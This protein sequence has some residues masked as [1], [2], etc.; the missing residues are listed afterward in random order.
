MDRSDTMNHE[1]A[2]S[3]FASE[4]YLLDEMTEPER[5]TFEEH[6]FACMAC[7]EDVRAGALM[8]D[9][10]REGLLP[11]RADGNNVHDMAA[12]AAWRRR[13]TEARRWYQSAFIPWA[14]AAS[15]AVIAGYQATVTPGRLA[16]QPVAL[17][18]VTLRPAS[19][20]QEPKVTTSPAATVVT[21]AVDLSSSVAGPSLGYAIRTA[22]GAAVASGS[23]PAP[24][25]G[26]PLLLLVPS[27]EIALPGRYILVVGDTEYPF[28]VVAQ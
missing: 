5:S 13:N 19:R 20:G 27:S 1:Q 9:G 8:R 14:A 3:T 17:T 23:V 15:L 12:S 25:A 22:A 6:Y 11:D 21:L 2:V 26:A 18:P 24:P 10:V 7:A 16:S 28:E 4:R